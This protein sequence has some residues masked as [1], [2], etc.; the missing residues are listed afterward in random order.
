[1]RRRSGLVISVSSV[2]SRLSCPVPLLEAR[3][4]WSG[5]RPAAEGTLAGVISQIPGGALADAVRWKRGLAAIGIGMICASALILALIPSFALVF[6]A[7]ILHG[8]TG[9]IVTPAIT[10][11]SLGLVG[12]EQCHFGLGATISST[13]Q[14][15]P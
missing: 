15:T 7:E 2:Q 8:L 1:V 4:E 10:A 6:F 5:D 3:R 11:I 9:G 14:A 13:P 12:G